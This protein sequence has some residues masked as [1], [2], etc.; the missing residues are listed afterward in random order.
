M[1]VKSAIDWHELR[2]HPLV[3]SVEA[4][5]LDIPRGEMVYVATPIRQYLE[6]GEAELCVQFAA[7]WAAWLWSEGLTP[8]TPA[9]MTIPPI[10]SRG[11]DWVGQFLRNVGHDWWMQ[12]LLPLMDACPWCAVPPIRGWEVS[13]GAWQEAASFARWG[14]PVR[15]IRGRA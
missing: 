9:L 6:R 15:L 3:E 1:L 10:L 13:E 14:Q 8:V 5:E 12:R 11:D 7:E 2:Q 4:A